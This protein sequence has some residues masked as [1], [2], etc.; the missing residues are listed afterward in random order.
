MKPNVSLLNSRPKKGWAYCWGTDTCLHWCVAVMMM[1]HLIRL[2]LFGVLT[3]K[4]LSV[5]EHPISAW[6]SPSTKI[7][8]NCISA[9][10][11]VFVYMIW[12]CLSWFHFAESHSRLNWKMKRAEA[13]GFRKRKGLCLI[14]SFFFLLLWLALGFNSGEL[15]SSGI[16]LLPW[17]ITSYSHSSS[18]LLILCP[19]NTTKMLTCIDR[20]AHGLWKVYKTTALYMLNTQCHAHKSTWTDARVSNVYH[21]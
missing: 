11:K 20:K 4:S 8:T 17:Q 3:L 9:H 5:S 10:Y 21:V 6:A 7:C 15:L 13:E 1:H 16:P 12:E 2:Q 19:A 18:I 14:M